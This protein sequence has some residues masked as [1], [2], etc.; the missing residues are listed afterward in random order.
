MK[1]VIIYGIMM[2]ALTGC[3]YSI[4]MIHSSGT[5]TDLVDENQAVT[6][7]IKTDLSIPLK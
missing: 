2:Q 7:D 1:Y 6:P 5:A 3:T 4:N